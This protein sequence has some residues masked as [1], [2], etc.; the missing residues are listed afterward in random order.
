MPGYCRRHIVISTS[1]IFSKEDFQFEIRFSNNLIQNNL[2][3][4]IFT[5]FLIEDETACATACVYLA[6]NSL[7]LQPKKSL[8]YI[9]KEFE[10]W[11]RIGVMGWNSGARPWFTIEDEVNELMA[12][13]VGA[14]Q[15]EVAMMNSLTVNLHLMMVPFY[16]PTKDRY[17]ILIEAGSFP[18]DLYAAES[19]V[20]VH[21]FRSEEAI[22]QI[23][24]REGEETLRTEDIIETIQ[25]EKFALIILPGIQYTTGQL[26]DMEKITAI[27]YACGAR[28]GFDLAHAVANVQLKLILPF[29]VATST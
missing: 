16:T 23:K 28:V 24:P 25:K 2:D 18:S 6:G 17:K 1:S 12:K 4:F 15:S 14:K 10:K 20:N 8:L 3:I 21:G 11:Q 26:L 22:V 27:G 9:D 5:F 7:E 13:I 19:Q 29:G